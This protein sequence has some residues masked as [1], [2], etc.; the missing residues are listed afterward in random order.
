MSDLLVAVSLISDDSGP[1]SAYSR[2]C[3]GYLKRAREYLDS[4]EPGVYFCSSMLDLAT[5]SLA[6]LYTEDT[7]KF[8]SKVVIQQLKSLPNVDDIQGPFKPLKKAKDVRCNQA[9]LA[10]AL[11]Y[12]SR[13]EQRLL[14]ADGLQVSRL[15]WLLFY[16]GIALTL[17]LFAVPVVEINSGRGVI[18]WPVAH[19]GPALVTQ[20]VAAV[21]VGAVGCG[22]RIFQRTR[23]YQR[24]KHD[25][26]LVKAETQK[27]PPQ[28][29]SLW[30]Q[31][32]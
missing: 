26:R 9:V 7:V 14:L 32:W 12:F 10:G 28:L 4:D 2:S 16:M 20:L 8:R 13:Q 30:F 25:A 11:K 22:R 6:W 21:T 5:S 27:S 3:K 18:G 1:Q 19:I 15:R 31:H 29:L 23:Q 17:L 24:F